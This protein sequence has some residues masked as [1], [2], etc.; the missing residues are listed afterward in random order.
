MRINGDEQLRQGGAPDGQQ[1]L[2]NKDEQLAAIAA[3]ADGF[4]MQGLQNNRSTNG[5][6]C[7]G[8]NHP[9]ERQ[10]NPKPPPVKTPEKGLRSAVL[11]DQPTP[12]FARSAYLKAAARL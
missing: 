11:P 6:F 4:H 8:A 12:R 5:K 2:C 1:E 3:L 9:S 10:E 7:L